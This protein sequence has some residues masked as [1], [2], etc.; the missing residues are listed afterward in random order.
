MIDDQVLRNLEKPC[1]KS[2]QIPTIPLARDPCLL[3]RPRREILDL[4]LLTQSET[5]IVVHARREIEVYLVPVQGLTLGFR[6]VRAW[7]CTFHGHDIYTNERPEYHGQMQ[8]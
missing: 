3:K 4:A 2:R 7:R 5:K 1:G 8:K 6:G